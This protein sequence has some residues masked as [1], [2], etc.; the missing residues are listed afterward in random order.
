MI[1]NLFNRSK[2]ADAD[3][4]N[5]LG[6]PQESLTRFSFCASNKP[7]KV[8]NWF[9][10]LPITNY[11][12]VASQLYEA[13][14]EISR[15]KLSN[16]ARA[17]IL[18]HIR[19]LV[20]NC[21]S[22]ITAPLTKKPLAIS[23]A[24]KKTALVAQALLKH[25]AV[26]YAGLAVSCLSDKKMTPPL[27]A[28]YIHRS[29]TILSL[30]LK[31][32]YRLYTLV[33]SQ[34]WRL[35]N[36]VYRLARNHDLHNI[37][38]PD[39]YD[40]LYSGSCNHRYLT[41]LAL[42]CARPLQLQSNEIEQLYIALNG[43][44]KQLFIEQYTPDAKTLF[45]VLSDADTEPDYIDAF[46]QEKLQAAGLVF[47][48]RVLLQQIE[49]TNQQIA[50]NKGPVSFSLNQHLALHWGTRV[51]RKNQRIDCEAKLEVCIGLSALHDQLT[52]GANF[53]EFLHGASQAKNLTLSADWSD[54]SSVSDSDAP[55]PTTGGLTFTMLVNNSGK[56]GFQLQ[57]T[58]QVPKKLQAGELIGF[59]EA[60]KRN[61]Q[62]AAVRWV[63]RS[64]KSGIQFG[65]M[66]IGRRLEAY[67]ASTVTDK[68]SDSDFL[69]V[70]LVNEGA[71]DG[72]PSLVTPNAV[73][74]EEFPI[75]LKKRGSSSRI[76]IKQRLESSG[77]YNQYRYHSI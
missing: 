44:V 42:A 65:V 43:W 52:K 8:K 60:G 24:E 12:L 27:R 74:S 67:G 58:D 7:V 46:D 72:S 9:D 31:N 47:D 34:V 17:D 11:Q 25:L 6:L 16:T 33:P 5:T 56:Y 76:Q 62:L 69:R 71:L 66:F 35:T 70:L 26:A 32:N 53:E 18:E 39:A 36:G 20:L 50:A 15:V 75:T 38:I 45:A 37:N 73:F 57:C 10:Q 40:A 41:T 21:V 61:W 59:R 54:A 22:A 64:E 3:Q 55:A 4:P 30:L 77:C 51:T 19:P 28:C 1:S 49:K 48:F 29:L 2:T 23:E 63:K 14:P 68:G 13:L